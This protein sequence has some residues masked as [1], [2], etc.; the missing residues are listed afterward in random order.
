METLYSSIVHIHNFYIGNIKAELS[1]KQLLSFVSKWIAS[2]RVR[3]YFMID[4]F[5][6]E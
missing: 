1:I 2:N 3:S 4:T 6:L 5:I